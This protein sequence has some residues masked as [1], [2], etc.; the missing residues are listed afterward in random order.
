MSAET[1]SRPSVESTNVWDA[2]ERDPSKRALL[3]VVFEKYLILMKRYWVNTASG[4]LANYLMFAFV[5]FGGQAAAPS[6]VENNLAGI[7]VGFF[8]W[9]MSWGAFQQGAQSLS[10]EAQWGTLEQQY[11]TPLGLTWVL[12]ARL[13]AD[14]TM[15]VV[16]GIVMLLSMMVT[17]GTWLAVD[18]LTV[19][20]LAFLTMGSAAGLGFAFGGLALV[21]KRISSVFL[22]VQFLLLGAINAPDAPGAAL[23]PLAL[24]TDLLHLAM[25]TSVPL[26]ELPIADLATLLAVTAGYLVTGILALRYAIDVARRRGI[27][28]HY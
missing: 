16:T 11:M 8:V 12:V 25:A 21:Y 1:A 19:G 15:T 24:G 10:Q 3:R 28:G 20:P 13:A 9:S 26:W 22:I 2:D 14:I 27:M 18:P 6:I 17:S 4:L 23:L 7:I 5:F